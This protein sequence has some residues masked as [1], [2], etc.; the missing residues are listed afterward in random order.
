MSHSWETCVSLG[1]DGSPYPFPETPALLTSCLAR[2]EALK[3]NL[4]TLVCYICTT[5][6][7]YYSHQVVGSCVRLGRNAAPRTHR[8]PWTSVQL[9]SNPTAVPALLT[10][11]HYRYR[12]AAPQMSLFQWARP[13]LPPHPPWPGLA[14]VVD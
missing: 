9:T 4:P 6:L 11:L 2:Q 12:P 3:G 1:W 7:C 14:E 5:L 8:T 13:H 10:H